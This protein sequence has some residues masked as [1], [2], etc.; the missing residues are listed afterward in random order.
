MSKASLLMVLGASFGFLFVMEGLLSIIHKISLFS[1]IRVCTETQ[2]LALTV[3]GFSLMI[4]SLLLMGFWLQVK[5]M[6]K[7]G[8][9]EV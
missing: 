1:D 5:I 4:L 7:L 9:K 8:I 2:A 6:Q 3:A